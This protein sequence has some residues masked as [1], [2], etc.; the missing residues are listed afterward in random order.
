MNTV[1]FLVLAWAGLF[2]GCSADDS[3][4][5]PGP[6]DADSMVPD[7][8]ALGEDLEHVYLY[9]YSQ[10]NETERVI[11]LSEEQEVFPSFL[12]VRQYDE[13][14][15]FY[16]FFEGRFSAEQRNLSTGS[17]QSL[18][19][20]YEVSND[21][22]VIWGTNTSSHMFFG[23]YSPVGSGNFGM[24][25][26]HIEDQ[27]TRE[28]LVENGVQ[29][30]YEPLLHEGKLFL[31]YRSGEGIYRTAIFD[32][33]TL[34]RLASWDLG[35]ETAS[36]FLS[37]EGDMAVIRGDEDGGYVRETYDLLSLEATDALAFQ[38]NRFFSP[39]PVQA[40]LADDILYYLHFYAQPSRVPFAPAYYDFIRA[41]NS[42]LDMP[43]IIADL[44]AETGQ[45]ISLTAFRYDTGSRSFLLGYTRDYQKGEFEGGVL[46]ISRE[47]DVLAT[48]PT[49][50]IPVFF[51]EP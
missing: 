38:L 42:I 17:T 11:D 20:V 19:N 30:V 40:A 12:T 33:T 5:G 44:E 41:E 21:Q 43:G 45:T 50:F 1:K 37:A 35:M 7:F 6:G 49:P 27:E 24:R 34:E 15:T 51:L 32:A 28:I 29:N 3:D 2:W 47:G 39:G 46:V 23:Y 25:A 31:T 18:P 36:L 9:S 16:S 48:F 8:L 14:L 13:V 4:P 10:D 22:S 26:V